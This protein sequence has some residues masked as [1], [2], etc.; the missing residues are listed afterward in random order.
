MDPV[1]PADY[2]IYPGYAVQG[3]AFDDDGIAP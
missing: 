1:D 2:V 3:Q